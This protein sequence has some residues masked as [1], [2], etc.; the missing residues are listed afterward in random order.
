MHLYSR[1]LP[2][3]LVGQRW[4]RLEGKVPSIRGELQELAQKEPAVRTNVYTS[5]VSFQRTSQQRPHIGVVARVP[6]F[7]FSDG[8]RF[9]P[10]GRQVVES[11]GMAL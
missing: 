8:G 9:V 5:R 6:Q 1:E 11:P 7:P 10:A 4:D 3:Q 2:S